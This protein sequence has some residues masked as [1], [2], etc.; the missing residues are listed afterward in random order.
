[1]PP[2][3]TTH[4]KPSRTSPW[5][6][7]P[8]TTITSSPSSSVSSLSVADDP[9][10]EQTP[11]PTPDSDRSDEKTTAR[12]SLSWIW[13]HGY[14]VGAT[15]WH[16]NR[17]GCKKTLSSASTTHVLSHMKQYHRMTD[18]ER[19]EPSAPQDSLQLAE[20]FKRASP[21]DCHMMEKNL[22]E[23]MLRDRI[24]FSQVESMSFRKF[25]ASIR[26]DDVSFIP[27]SGDTVRSW[28]LARF[29]QARDEIKEHFAMAVS[30]I[31]ISCDMWSSP[32]NYA[33]LGVGGHF[34]NPDHRQRTSMIGMPRVS[35]AHTGVNIA[36]VVADVLQLYNIGQRLGYMML[37]N[38]TNNDT[39][40][41]AVHD[42]LAEREIEPLTIMTT[43]ERRLRCFRHI[44]NL[45]VKAL[46]FGKDIDALEI[47]SAEFAI[48]RKIGAVGKLHNIVR[49]I[50][51]SPQ[52]RERFVQLQL[53]A[54]QAEEAF[55][56]RQ[57]N[58]TRWNSM[59]AMIESALGL[60]RAIDKF[61]VAA[62]NES[63]GT[64]PRGERLEQD[65]L[66]PEDWKELEDLAKL[67]EPFKW[68]TT[69]LVN[70]RVRSEVRP[71]FGPRL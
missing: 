64:A 7:A 42:E 24:P 50:R 15:D 32:N 13:N 14:R 45:V 69:G 34:T 29:N 70:G 4:K 39:A 66:V 52:R 11:G 10:N 21:F 36:S 43:G 49:W 27:R 41:K 23:W 51:A 20:N 1:M 30:N 47:S 2:Q 48:W 6:K 40:V 9:I 58:D 18:T 67:L 62:I 61:I 25:I 16:C 60:Q 38:A 12:G 17:Q 46:L 53:E 44:L 71:R 56:V 22:V 55:M 63:R 28:I 8:H 57:N 26:H 65:Q 31:H 33:L 5:T 68:L 35:G 3:R 37:D 54:L 59:Y 19:G